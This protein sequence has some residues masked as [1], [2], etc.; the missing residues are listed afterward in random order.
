[1]SFLNKRIEINVLTL[2]VIVI[3]TGVISAHVA[4]TDFGVQTIPE[5]FAVI[6]L[7]LAGFGVWMFLGLFQQLYGKKS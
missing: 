2:I 3:V 1:M 6:G 4:Q 7:A 5:I